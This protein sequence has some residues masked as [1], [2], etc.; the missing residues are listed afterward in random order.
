MSPGEFSDASDA[1][2]NSCQNEKIYVEKFG[3]AL[4]TAG[5]PNHAIVDTGR[6]GKQDLREEWGNWY[7]RILLLFPFDNHPG[8]IPSHPQRKQN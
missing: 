7:V 6:N 4:K 8:D 2:Y 3:A 1:K 5:M